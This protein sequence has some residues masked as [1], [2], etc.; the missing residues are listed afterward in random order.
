MLVEK[1]QGKK[2]NFESGILNH[3]FTDANY[4]RTVSRG[5]RCLSSVILITE[6]AHMSAFTAIKYTVLCSNPFRLRIKRKYSPF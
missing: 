4:V 3:F 1:M 2:I 6:E 5:G